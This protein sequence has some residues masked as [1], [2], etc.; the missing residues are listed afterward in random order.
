MTSKKFGISP[1]KQDAASIESAQK[2]PNGIGFNAVV[3]VRRSDFFYGVAA[4]F[5]AGM[6]IGG[7][8]VAFIIRGLGRI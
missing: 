8:L 7:I 1:E 2:N 6:L 3:S 5:V 4:A